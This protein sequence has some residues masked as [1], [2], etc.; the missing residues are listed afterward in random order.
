MSRQAL[1]LRHRANL[2]ENPFYG[3]ETNCSDFLGPPTVTEA[4]IWSKPM[5]GSRDTPKSVATAPPRLCRKQDT[6]RE[7]LREHTPWTQ[8]K[9]CCVPTLTSC[10]V[11]HSAA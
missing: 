3:H 2:S 5:C 1:D 8:N 9:C 6:T 11:S 7:P 4:V 10:C